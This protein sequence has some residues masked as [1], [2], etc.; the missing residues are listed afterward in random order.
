MSRFR[1]FFNRLLDKTPISTMVLGV[2]LDAIQTKISQGNQVLFNDPTCL[3]I[4]KKTGS[5]VTL[6]KKACALRGKAPHHLQVVFPFEKDCIQDERV[7]TVFMQHVLDSAIDKI[8]SKQLYRY[9]LRVA[10]HSGFRGTHQ[11]MFKRLFRDMGYSDAQLLSRTAVA[12]TNLVKTKQMGKTGC[13]VVIGGSHTDIALVSEG[14]V[15]E[16]I[17]ESIGFSDF[18]QLV[19]SAVRV[20]YATHISIATAR[21]IINEI[22]FVPVDGEISNDKRITVK[23]KNL[24][25]QL[26]VTISVSSSDFVTDLTKLSNQI[27]Q[28]LTKLFA[29]AST[30]ILQEVLEK[31]IAVS[32]IG[33][34]SGLD[35]SISVQTNCPVVVSRSREN[36]VV[37]GL[38]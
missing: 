19:V 20:Q 29:L 33:Y 6:G 17:S 26:P 38:T 9:A 10:I 25:S 22:G 13:L 32:G 21:T 31:G 5:V 11:M 23:G 35:A 1:S 18:L 15:V 27:G 16:E 12:Y 7:F 8:S 37:L 2:D 36:D 3:V 34:V 30:E 28:A 24:I 14:K 4:H